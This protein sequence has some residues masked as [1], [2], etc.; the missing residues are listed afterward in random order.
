MVITE[1]LQIVLKK[2]ADLL[3]FMEL[4]GNMEILLGHNTLYLSLSYKNLGMYEEA[5]EVL[6][7]KNFLVEF[8]DHLISPLEWNY[9][10]WLQFVNCVCSIFKPAGMQF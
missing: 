5:I 1:K 3:R 8:G 2:T 9:S 10:F 4:E 7:E 6:E